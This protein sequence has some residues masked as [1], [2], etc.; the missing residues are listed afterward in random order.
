M[1]GPKRTRAD[2]PDWIVVETSLKEWG[3]VSDKLVYR[4]GEPESLCGDTVDPYV[5]MD[6]VKGFPDQVDR[7]VTC[8]ACRWLLWKEPV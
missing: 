8:P 7:R 1:A 6:W 3:H 2:L 5:S 4:Q